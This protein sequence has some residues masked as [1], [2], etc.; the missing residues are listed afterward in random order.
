MEQIFSSIN[1]IINQTIAWLGVAGPLLGCVLI[2]FE[3]I[4]PI[5]PLCV[6]ITLNCMA[7]GNIIGF[8]ISWIST[9]LGCLMSFFLF[10]KK[11]KN[12]FDKK[13]RVKDNINKTMKVVEK[14]NACHLAMIVAVPFTPS[15]LI[16]IA[17][18]LSKMDTKR[19]VT[20]ILIGK[21]FMVYFWGSIGMNLIQSIKN[22]IVLVKVIIMMLIAYLLS[23]LVTKKFKL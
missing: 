22:P 23:K 3:S 1:E 8:I 20:G 19:F 16:N 7:F 14:C 21:I 13:L 2:I 12:W 18:G 15:F 17:A 11:I 5:L 10:R 9:C 6:F 4:I